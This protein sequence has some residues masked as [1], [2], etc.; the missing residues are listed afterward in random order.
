MVHFH[1]CKNM[2]FIALNLQKSTNIN[3]TS[4][5]QSPINIAYKQINPQMATSIPQFIFICNI[6]HALH[7]EPEQ[8]VH[9]LPLQTKHCFC[10]PDSHNLNKLEM[11]HS[12]SCTEWSIYMNAPALTLLKIFV[13][14]SSIPMLTCIG[15]TQ[16]RALGPLS[17]LTNFNLNKQS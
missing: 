16:S 1:A 5:S 7:C 6:H 2:W 9:R 17:I 3:T 13:H 4:Q 8:L 14:V 11:S 15:F 10:Q 12:G